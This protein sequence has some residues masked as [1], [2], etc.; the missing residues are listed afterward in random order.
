MPCLGR[1]FLTPSIVRLFASFMTSYATTRAVREQPSPWDSL[2]SMDKSFSTQTASIRLAPKTAADLNFCM[3]VAK[4]IGH[5]R[6][7]IL[8]LF[9]AL[10]ILQVSVKTFC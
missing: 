5:C 7:T 2:E 1:W 10:L 6:L 8:I 4:E 3:P 9:E